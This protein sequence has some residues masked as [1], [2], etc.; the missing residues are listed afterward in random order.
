MNQSIYFF[1]F[2]IPTIEAAGGRVLVKAT[3]EEVLIDPATQVREISSKL[4]TTPN[5]T[6]HTQHNQQHHTIYFFFM[7]NTTFHN[8]KIATFIPVCTFCSI[9]FY[10]ITI[11]CH[12][13][14]K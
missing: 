3:V 4:N 13:V 11:Y 10:R 7:M 9:S 14:D 1:V 12:I 2:S 5:T 8:R 6:H